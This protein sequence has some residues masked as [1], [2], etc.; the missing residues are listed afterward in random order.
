MLFLCSQ[1]NLLSLNRSCY[2]GRYTG[3]RDKD[4][5]ADGTRTSIGELEQI[6]LLNLSRFDNIHDVN[7]KDHEFSLLQC[8]FRYQKTKW[9]CFDWA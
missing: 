8:L 5:V 1:R 7:G 2:W 4:A 3:I 6:K 9:G